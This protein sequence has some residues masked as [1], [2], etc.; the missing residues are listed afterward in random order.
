VIAI[1]VVV[2][3]ASNRG[4]LFREARR[5]GVGPRGAV[6]ER[7]ESKDD[8]WRF[9]WRMGPHGGSDGTD[10]GFED[11][12]RREVALFALFFLIDFGR[13]C[14]DANPPVISDL[15]FPLFLFIDLAPFPRAFALDLPTRSLSAPTISALPNDDDFRSDALLF[16]FN[17]TLDL[18]LGAFNLTLSPMRDNAPSLSFDLFFFFLRPYCSNVL[19]LADP[20]GG[21]ADLVLFIVSGDL[22]CIFPFLRFDG[23]RTESVRVSAGADGAVLEDFADLVAL[24][25]CLP[26]RVPRTVWKYTSCRL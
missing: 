11:F 2:D 21:V 25:G 10:G 20:G 24:H 23:G 9:C 22:L 26:V 4:A 3:V 8:E 1:G 18:E 5:C 6:G 15:V 14:A 19:D 7:V 16:A 13:L 12:G 17:L